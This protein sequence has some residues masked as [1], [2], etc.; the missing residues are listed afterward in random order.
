VSK[1][2]RL[3]DRFNESGDDIFILKYGLVSGAF[4]YNSIC[5]LTETWIDDFPGSK[6]LSMSFGGIVKLRTYMGFWSDLWGER[7]VSTTASS[8]L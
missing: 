8:Q 2:E 7:R 4:R 5:R 1:K 3:D 6:Q